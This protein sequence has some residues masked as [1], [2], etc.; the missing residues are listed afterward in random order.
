MFLLD[1][2]T[3]RAPVL[4]APEPTLLPRLRVCF[5]EFPYLRCPAPEAA[6]LGDLLR[7]RYGRP[8]A[9][10]SFHAPPRRAPASS[11]RHASERGPPQMPL[12]AARCG[13]VEARGPLPSAGRRLSFPFAARPARLRP[14]SLLRKPFSSSALGAQVR[15]SLQ[16][17][18][19]RTLQPAPPRPF[20]A[21]APPG[22]WRASLCAPRALGGSC[23]A[24]HF[25]RARVRQVGC[26]T[27]LP[28]CRPPWPP[29]C[30]PDPRPAFALRLPAAP[31]ARARF[32]PPRAPCL[33]GPAHRARRCPRLRSSRPPS[34]ALPRATPA[35]PLSCGTFRP[36]PATRPFD[37]SFAAT[38]RSRGRFARQA[39]SEPLPGLPPPSLSPG[40]VHRL[41]GRAARARRSA[42]A[43]RS[44][45]SARARAALLGPCF[46]T[47]RPL[48]PAARAC[49]PCFAPF[50]SAPAPL[51]SLPSRY[52]SAIGLPRSLAFG[53][54][55]HPSPCAPV[56]GY[57]A[58]RGPDGA[59]TLSGPAHRRF[60][61]PPH[62]PSGSPR[63]PP[64]SLAA[65]PGIRLRFSSAAY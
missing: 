56:H 28:G 18:R 50:H 65:T 11:P 34:S 42:R 35:R 63:A 2:Q 48:A 57:S 64:L 62:T 59:S 51:F 54:S 61:A 60:R 14:G 33:P 24:V 15:Y 9:R 37:G 4:A 43:P 8:R 30:C 10:A 1:S 52:F 22:Y 32:G 46:K 29:P 44:P 25:R 20:P 49:A 6:R 17:L 45:R 7:F 5:A 53:G 40:V 3:P 55:L 36:E 19:A 38:P 16:D 31:Y 41:S 23:S 47:G 58:P 26:D 21:C 39:P 13:G 12:C 27:L